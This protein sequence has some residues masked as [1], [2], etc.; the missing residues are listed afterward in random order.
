VS[1]L[2][3]AAIF[4]A[5]SHSNIKQERDRPMRE[6]LIPIARVLGAL[7]LV[8][9]LLAGAGAYRFYRAVA[10]GLPDHGLA[11]GESSWHG[12]I[13]PSARHV[14]F[15]PLSAMPA[16][17]M[18][19]F[20]AAREPDFLTRE[21]YNPLN[22]WLWRVKYRRT[23][24]ISVAYVQQLLFC[25]NTP[26]G[27]L[28]LSKEDLLRYR[29]ERDL[30]RRSILET[31]INTDYMGKGAYGMPAAALAYFQKPL[32]ELSTGE[33]AFLGS[34]S[35]TKPVSQAIRDDLA[36]KFRNLILDRMVG[37]GALPA[38]QAAA[39]KLEPLNLQL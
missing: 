29:I 13:P 39:A 2:R 21:A 27:Y 15:V 5:R 11:E 12:C 14:E 10:S 24:A 30:P 18:N 36:L 22:S 33:L 28:R 37:M 9:S 3:I 7:L 19:A 23:F 6:V 26:A 38:E 17:A 8:A 32:T 34:L 25:L 16:N 35:G 20:L 4:V 31:V 1:Y